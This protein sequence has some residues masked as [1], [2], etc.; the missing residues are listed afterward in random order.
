MTKQEKCPAEDRGGMTKQQFLKLSE[1]CWDYN[2]RNETRRVQ[3]FESL[4]LERCSIALFEDY[5][6]INCIRTL[7]TGWNLP[8]IMAEL[9]RGLET[10]LTVEDLK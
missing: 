5:P 2:R 10:L 6:E 4:D 3:I 8:E 9:S 7:S 1:L